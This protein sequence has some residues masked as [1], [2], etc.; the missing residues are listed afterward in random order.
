M[1]GGVKRIVSAKRKEFIVLAVG[2]KNSYGYD[3]HTLPL[4]IQLVDSSAP[5]ARQ[6]NRIGVVAYYQRSS[7]AIA[8]VEDVLSRAEQL[9]DTDARFGTLGI[10]FSARADDCRLRLAWQ[11][12]A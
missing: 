8:A 5:D 6:F 11:T 1:L 2:D 12:Q 7:R 3:E 10:G 9:R 4:L